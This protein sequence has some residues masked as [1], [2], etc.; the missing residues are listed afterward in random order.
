MITKTIPVSMKIVISYAMKWDTPYLSL[1][2]SQWKL[3]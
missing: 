1:I 2:E 3:R